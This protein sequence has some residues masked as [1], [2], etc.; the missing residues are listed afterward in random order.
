MKKIEAVYLHKFDNEILNALRALDLGGFTII[1]GKGRG[2]GPRNVREGHGRYVEPFNEIDL[3]Y[4]V[5]EDAK[6]PSV[7]DA[8]TKVT[9][10]GGLGDGK[11]FI[12]KV[13]EVIDIS[14]LKKGEKFL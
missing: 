5:V 9:H 11:I 2:R 8:I 6:V 7:V 4:L 13:D 10:T 12:S 1:S 14:T 3:L